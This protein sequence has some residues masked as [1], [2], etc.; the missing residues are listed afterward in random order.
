MES[1]EPGALQSPYNS[2]ALSFFWCGGFFLCVAARRPSRIRCPSSSE[3][4]FSQPSIVVRRALTSGRLAPFKRPAEGDF[5]PVLLPAR[6]LEARTSP[7]LPPPLYY[8]FYLVWVALSGFDSARLNSSLSLQVDRRFSQTPI[9]PGSASPFSG[10]GPSLALPPPE[11]IGP[12]LTHSY[13][14]IPLRNARTI[15]FFVR[16]SPR[17]LWFVTTMPVTLLTRAP[18]LAN[19]SIGTVSILLASL[20][21][22][23]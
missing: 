12:L 23:P 20:R 21:R 17:P 2:T 1:S 10:I 13:R 4:F 19:F 3:V 5:F 22:P 11:G 16:L 6:F 15:P 7:F 14:N 9:F 8:L 18:A